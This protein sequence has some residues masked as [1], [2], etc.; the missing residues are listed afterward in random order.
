MIKNFKTMKKLLL[1]LLVAVFSLSQ[2]LAQESTFKQGD[3]VV[4]LGIGFGST[5][6]TGSYYT[7]SVPPLSASLEVGVKDGVLDKG[8]IGIGGMVAY[9]ASKWEYSGWGW[10]YS[11]FIIGAR[12]AFHYPLLNKLDTYT[13]IVLGYNIATS[14]EFGNA[15]VGYNY[16]ASS[17]GIVASWFVGGRYYFSN[18]F[19]AMA[20]IGYGITYLKLGVALKF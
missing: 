16:S 15:I 20:E 2:L 7:N 12:G 6:Y 1:A 9:S 14:K 4:N 3:K 17:G 8:S 11:N 18:N 5:L 10:K 13:G 19:G